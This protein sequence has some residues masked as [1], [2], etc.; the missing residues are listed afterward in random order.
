MT[1]SGQQRDEANSTGM[2]LTDDREF[3]MLLI[4]RCT[5]GTRCQSVQ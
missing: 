2:I 1:R 5:G 3:D 4:R